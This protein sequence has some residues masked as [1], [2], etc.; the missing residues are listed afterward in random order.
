MNAR[1]KQC[2]R[3]ARNP[4]PLTRPCAA[5]AALAIST[6][7]RAAASGSAKGM[8]LDILHAADFLVRP[9]HHDPRGRRRIQSKRPPAVCRAD[10]R[11]QNLFAL[12]R[13]LSPGVAILIKAACGLCLHL[14]IPLRNFCRCVLAVTNCGSG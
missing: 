14:N 5:S 13:P 4:L 9:T 12:K 8:T 6:I 1:A 7:L 2:S 11:D 10:V 3:A